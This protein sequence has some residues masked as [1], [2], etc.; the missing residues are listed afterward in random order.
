MQKYGQYSHLPPPSFLRILLGLSF[1]K[2]FFYASYGDIMCAFLPL[3]IYIWFDYPVETLNIIS[4]I[5]MVSLAVV[6]KG[7]NPNVH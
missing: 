7:R 6:V 4:C 3:S 5:Y 2:D 1:L